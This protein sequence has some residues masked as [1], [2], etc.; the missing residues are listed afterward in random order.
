MVQ[1]EADAIKAREIP[2]SFVIRD[3]NE[4]WLLFTLRSNHE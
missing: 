1:S 4:D 3:E 2:D